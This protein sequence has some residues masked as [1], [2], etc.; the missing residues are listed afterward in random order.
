MQIE[1]RHVG[2]IVILDVYGKMT[3]GDGDQLLKDKLYSLVHRGHINILLN[4]AGVSYLDSAGIGQVVAS[5]TTIRRAGG[6]LALV[7][8]TKKIQDLLAIAKLLTV[9]DAYEN[10]DHALRSFLVHA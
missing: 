3:L 5:F 6:R 10:E 1:E 9:F 4:L 2:N 7:N 8:L